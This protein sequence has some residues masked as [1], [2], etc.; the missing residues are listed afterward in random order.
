MSSSE[1][2]IFHKIKNI[3]LDSIIQIRKQNWKRKNRKKKKNIV[4]YKDKDI[5]FEGTVCCWIFTDT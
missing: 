2:L 5:G 4:I 1:T 3:S